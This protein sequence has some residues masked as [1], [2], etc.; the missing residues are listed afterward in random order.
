[1]FVFVWGTRV[2]EDKLGAIAIDCPICGERVISDCF[3]VYKASHMYFIRGKFKEVGR[4]LR[5][6]LC[7]NAS[8]LPDSVSTKVSSPDQ[9]VPSMEFIKDT[10]PNLLEG[11]KQELKFDNEFPVGVTRLRWALCNGILQAIRGQ[12]NSS[13]AAG[14]AE[15]LIIMVLMVALFS[16]MLVY[17]RFQ[18]SP[19]IPLAILIALT[20][21]LVG[22]LYVLQDILM[23]RA[24]YKLI[25]KDIQRYL[26]HQNE[27]YN[28]LLNCAVSLGRP[29]KKVAK[30]LK[31]CIRRS[32]DSM[33]IPNLVT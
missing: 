30:Y 3:V 4:Y 19:M 14:N 5:C 15:G 13:K 16:S 8:R 28:V 10:N 7:L 24:V 21:S 27:N 17:H 18:Q 9:I 29:F 33:G 20:V 26:Y 23:F 1:M 22:A 31:W 2:K 11:D 25:N 12:N 6:R 32:C